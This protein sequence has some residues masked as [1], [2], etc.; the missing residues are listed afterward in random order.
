M[1]KKQVFKVWTS[2]LKLDGQ[3]VTLDQYLNGLVDEGFQVDHVTPLTWI[4]SSLVFL[5]SA[6]IAHSYDPA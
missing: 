1:K 2:E 6:L 5:T 4:N 3:H